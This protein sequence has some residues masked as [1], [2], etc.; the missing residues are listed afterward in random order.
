M[1]RDHASRVRQ[2]YE[3]PG[4]LGLEGLGNQAVLKLM[5]PPNGDPDQHLADLMFVDTSN[6]AYGIF[7][8]EF[9][10]FVDHLLRHCLYPQEQIF[11]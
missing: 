9:T 5:Y 2:L 11:L 8:V 7:V 3:N 4:L 6:S 1:S 10:N